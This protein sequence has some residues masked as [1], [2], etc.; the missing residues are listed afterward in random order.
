MNSVGTIKNLQKRAHEAWRGM[1]WEGSRR[2]LVEA[3]GS[4]HD[5]GILHTCTKVAKKKVKKMGGSGEMS[6]RGNHW[7]HKHKSQVL[8]L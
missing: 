6:R 8:F 5:Q 7:S 1:C 3:S 2:E 4:V